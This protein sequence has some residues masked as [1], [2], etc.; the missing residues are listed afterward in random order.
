MGQICD[1]GICVTNC[2]CQ[3]CASGKACDAVTGQC[4]DP[5]CAS[6]ICGIGTFCS[7]GQCLDN[8]ASAVCPGG[9][10]YEHWLVRCGADARRAASDA[11]SGFSSRALR[12]GDSTARIGCRKMVPAT[13]HRGSVPSRRAVAVAAPFQAPAGW[14]RRGL[15]SWGSGS[16]AAVVEAG[17]SPRVRV[18]GSAPA[19]STMVSRCSPRRRGSLDSSAVGE[20]ECESRP[21]RCW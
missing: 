16:F 18:V 8:C 5:S 21:P 14:R 20:A 2:V 15:W 10:T 17:D 1:E 13:A 19:S 12:T 11:G 7:S 9:Q 4:V 6:K 3:P